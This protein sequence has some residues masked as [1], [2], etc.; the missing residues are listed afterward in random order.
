MVTS[1]T[2]AAMLPGPK[3]C[4]NCGQLLSGRQR[5]FCSPGCRSLAARSRWLAQVYGLSVADY[6]TIL[7]YQQ[8]RC[9]ICRKPPK[10]GRSLAVD[11][12]HEDGQRGTVRGLL[13]FFCNKRV[14][15]ARSAEVLVKTA[16]YVTCP[17]A[18]VA[19]GRVVVAPGRPKKPR[20]RRK[21]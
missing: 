1:S 8:G 16:E 14:L 19:L 11:H 2:G 7:E 17:P 13:C 4:D 15:G 10:A 21:R 3:E 9:G 12:A 6:N 18:V 20:R 5:R